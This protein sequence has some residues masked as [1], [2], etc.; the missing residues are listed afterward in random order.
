MKRLIPAALGALLVATVFVPLGLLLSRSGGPGEWLEAWR[1]AESRHALAGTLLTSAGAALV[2]LGLGLPFA[3]LIVRTDVVARG[4][5]KTV[6]TLPSAIPP[7]LWTMG[8]IALA[9]P[10]SGWLTLLVG[11]DRLDV[12][13]SAGIAFVLGTSA[14]PLVVLATAAALERIDPALEEAARLSGATAWETF[15]HVTL[16]LIAPAMLSGAALV[17]VF[18][19]ASFGVPYLLGVPANPPAPTLTTRI[20][21]EVLMGE[22]G[23]SRAASSSVQL[24]LVAVGVLS[25]NAWLARAGRVRLPRGKGLGA[26]VSA[27]GRSRGLISALAWT[28]VL[29]VILLPLGAVFLTGLQPTWGQWG[30]FTLKHWGVV[31]QPRTVAAAG[32]SVLLAAG[33]ALLVGAVGL[34][35]ALSRRRWLETLADAPSAIPGTVLALA[36]L[37]AFSRDL[38]F[39]AFERV[40]FVLALGNTVWLLLLSYVVKHLALGVRSASDALAQ[41]DPT[42]A[43]AARLSGAGPL[44]AFVDGVLPQVRGALV[45]AVL[46]TFFTCVSELTMS[47]LL[48][49][50][51]GDVL[52]TLLFELQSYADPA[53]A[54]VIASAL[55]LIVLAALVLQNLATRRA[56][57]R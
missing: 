15:R 51:G 9:N 44:R 8:W 1:S 23:L 35:I 48:I 52:G 45:G 54:A 34:L 29:L 21:A 50:T 33:A 39:I 7:Y 19:S 4:A 5:L 24:L 49:P 38:R 46:L 36:L 26:K 53:S 42:L 18:A 20:Y 27:L 56:E 32:V 10:K 41:A 2:A 14:L 37:V 28:T 6:V 11:R 31:L 43:E 17:F 3:W 22:S 25:I 13:G 55:L 57:A 40:A 12:Y 30:S 16:P 47:V